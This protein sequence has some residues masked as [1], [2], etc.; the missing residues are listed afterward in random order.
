MMMSVVRL[1]LAALAAGVCVVLLLALSLTL[2]VNVA[3]FEVAGSPDAMAAALLQQ[4]PGLRWVTVVDDV[5]IACYL[6]VTM[7][8]VGELARRPAAGDPHAAFRPWILWFGVAAGV[9]DLIENHHV[10]GLLHLAEQGVAVEPGQWALREV[11]SSVKWMLGHL[12]FVLVGLSLP[13]TSLGWRGLRLAMVYVQL[14]VGAL[15]LA[16]LGTE[17]GLV[18]GWAR[19][20]NVLAGFVILA[21]LLPWPSEDGSGARA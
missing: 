8:L 3:L 2:G 18:L 11:T 14:P 15:A 13:G 10:L 7:M 12:A 20:V 19:L 5:F 1:R 9:L 17:L 16:F 4:G 6:A 21:A